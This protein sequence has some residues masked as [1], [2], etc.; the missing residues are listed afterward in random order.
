[1]I[2]DPHILPLTVA[3]VWVK[4]NVDYGVHYVTRL[5]RM[6][7]RNLRR[8]HMFTALTDSPG[9][10]LQALTDDEAR[11]LYCNTSFCI[12]KIPSPAPGVPGWWAK[13]ELFNRSRLC[14]GEALYLDL[15]TVVLQDLGRLVDWRKRLA[16]YAVFCPPGGTFVPKNGQH[17]VRRFNT[18]VIAW[19]IDAMHHVWDK[20][21]SNPQVYQRAYWGDQDAIGAMLPP[22]GYS[23][24][25][26]NWV[27]RLSDIL[28]KKQSPVTGGDG[29]ACVVLCKKPKNEQAAELYPWI[30]EAWQ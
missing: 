16:Q 5:R 20:Y 22:F 18:S 12:I 15:D 1:M 28:N 19:Q 13:M 30:M 27:P 2:R 23:A 24:F 17:T 8:E 10:V 26:E 21:A 6:V 11:G 9:E 25:P 29:D 14:T 3:C 4:A 7:A